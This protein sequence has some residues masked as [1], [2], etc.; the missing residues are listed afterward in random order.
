MSID[1]DT[2]LFILLHNKLLYKSTEFR[3][4]LRLAKLI[5]LFSFEILRDDLLILPMPGLWALKFLLKGKREFINF[6]ILSLCF[7]CKFISH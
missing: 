4:A 7:E 2:G 1:W 6:F 3:P 5:L